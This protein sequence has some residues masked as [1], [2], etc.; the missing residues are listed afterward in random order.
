MTNLLP[1]DFQYVARFIHEHSAISL[2][3][4]KSYL[5]EARLGPIARR[6][7]LASL[8]ELVKRLRMGDAKLRDEVIDALTTN[9]TWFF[10]DH[11]PFELIRTTLLPELIERRRN[12]RRLRIWSAACSSGQE[13]YTLAMLIDEHFPQL[14]NWDV[15]IVATDISQEIL[16]RAQ[17]GYYYAHEVSRGLSQSTLRRFFTREGSGWR[18]KASTRERVRFR[19]LNLASFWAGLG[20]MDL[21]LMRNV[22]IYFDETTRLSIMARVENHMHKDGYLMLGA[23]ETVAQQCDR[24]ERLPHRL[25]ACY[26]MTP[27]R[28]QKDASRPGHRPV[29]L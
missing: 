15:E 14:S 19:K 1:Q 24:F 2:G 3:P 28:R 20:V 5:V 11:H 22:L 6:R 13:P 4:N 12:Q 23:A 26:Q 21:I 25:T 7:G 18:I 9:E 27:A 16:D 8:S 17:E 29:G 10:R